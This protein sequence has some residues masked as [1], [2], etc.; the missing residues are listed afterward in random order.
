MIAIDKFVAHI[1]YFNPF[2]RIG[3]IKRRIF[4]GK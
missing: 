2:P 3:Y 1:S 4:Y